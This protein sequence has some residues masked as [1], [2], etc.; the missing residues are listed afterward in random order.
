[1]EYTTQEIDT[2]LVEPLIR[3]H[4]H[5]AKICTCGHHNRSYVPRKRGGNAVS[6]GKNIQALVIY[7]HVVQCVPYERLQSMFKAV[8]GIEM[9]QGTISNIIRSA[10]K[11]AEPAIALIK[12]HICNSK[13]V[14]FDESGCYCNN[15]LDWSWIAQTVYHTLVFRANGRS[16]KVL[17]DMFGDTLQNMT[18]VT[19]RHSAYFALDFPSHQICLAHILRETQYLN[20]LDQKQQWSVNLQTLLREAI[21]LRNQIPDKVIDTSAWLARLDNILKENVEHLKDEFRRL[22]N[23]LIKCRDYIFKFLENPAIP[24]DNNASERGIRKLKIKQKISGTFRSDNG[25]DAF[26][27]FHSI[28]DTAWKN[29]QSPFKAILAIL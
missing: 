25:A 14:G 21:H 28:T 27:D 11:K 22:K 10:R 23:G 6:F 26:M 16:G 3:E 19:D 29:K 9:S 4:R 2:P 24:P 1:M 15:R 7:Y 8:F 20:E 5:Y 13:V 17:E 12:E 18:A